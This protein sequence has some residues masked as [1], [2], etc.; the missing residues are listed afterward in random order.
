M[1][2][3][4]LLIIFLVVFIDL[5][6]FGIVLPL[7]PR[8]SE[9]FGAVGWQIGAI[10]SSYSLMQFFFSPWWGKLSDRIGRRPVILVSTAGS[11]LSYALFAVAS[12]IEGE[13]GFWL[14]L[15]SRVSA[16]I[17]GS[18]LAVA[19]AYIADVTAHENR[20]KGM[21]VIG[22]AFGIGFVFGP[23]IGSLGYYYGGLT[24]PG[25]AA[26]VICGLN[27]FLAFLILPESRKSSEQEPKPRKRFEQCSQVL[28]QP[29]LRFLIG[30]YFLAIFCFA[31]FESI[32]PLL[33]GGFGYRYDQLGLFFAWCGVV[34]LAVNGMIGRLVKLCGE[35]I[36]IS[37]GLVG[38]GLSLLAFPL[39][40]QGNWILLL[41]ALALFAAC[42]SFNRSPSLG[43]ISMNVT[44]EE[45][46]SVLGVAQSAGALARI[47]APISLTAVY[48]TD[49]FGLPFFLCASIA[50][51][52]GMLAWFVLVYQG[53]CR[54]I[55]E[56]PQ[57]ET[58]N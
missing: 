20:S 41:L 33:L 9:Q 48:G 27:C 36:L 40:G 24:G 32:M 58:S 29:K 7:L 52:T 5:V 45:Q 38:V 12:G 28:Q 26:A 49:Y 42:S 50:L 4:T 18:N 2:K 23:A 37:A 1:K 21:A 57:V 3:P 19:S 8:Y 34:S 30:I 31:G 44:K 14:L 10:V 47:L 55:R 56:V 6:G 51:G 15:F 16:G 22:I 11:T 54:P 53:R 13:T 25:W 17:V 39:V 35:P 46:G 43:M